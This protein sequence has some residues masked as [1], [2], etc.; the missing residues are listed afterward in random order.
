[1]DFS[2]LITTRYSVRAYRADPVPEGVLNR[3][4]EA[5]R[6]APT[7]A[8]R[9]PFRIL[10]IPTAGREAELRRVYDRAWFVQAPLVLIMCA[11]P[12]EAWTRSDG[13]NYALVDATIAMDHLILAATEAGLGTCWVAAFDPVAARDVLGLSE[14]MEPVALTPLGYPADAPRPKQRKPLADLVDRERW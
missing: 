4:L 7:A 8:N 6:L 11:L 10:V 3:V 14:G 5:A 12:G 13:L 1:M 9:Q 2:S